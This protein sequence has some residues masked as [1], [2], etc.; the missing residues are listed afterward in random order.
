MDIVGVVF[1]Y[2]LFVDF[3]VGIGVVIFDM[4]GGVY[5]FV[6]FE[7]WVFVDFDFFFLF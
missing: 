4:F 6:W 5:L 1:L 7:C 3:L 2:E